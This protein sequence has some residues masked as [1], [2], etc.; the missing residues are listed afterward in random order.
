MENINDDMDI[1][2]L[3]DEDGKE[4]NFEVIATF[5]VDENEYAILLPSDRD[6][7]LDETEEGEEAYVL[8]IETDENGEEVLVGIDD[9]D[10][11]DMVIQAYEELMEEEAN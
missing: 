10:E 4:M 11:L 7:T 2:V 9:D 6:K 1:I 5:E 8:R 3:Y